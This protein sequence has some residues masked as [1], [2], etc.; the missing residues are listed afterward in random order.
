MLYLGMDMAPDVVYI[1][2][3]EGTL[4]A[5]IKEWDITIPVEPWAGW[6]AIDMNGLIHIYESKPTSTASG[7]FDDDEWLHTCGRCRYAG[8]VELTENED[9]QDLMV[10]LKHDH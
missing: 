5:Y 2:P 6:A 10:E 4:T 1:P 3:V 9:W 8:E 7:C